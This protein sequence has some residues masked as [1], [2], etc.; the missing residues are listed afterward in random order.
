MPLEASWKQKSVQAADHPL[1]NA[2]AD[3]TQH[4]S[5]HTPDH[6]LRHL[7]HLSRL[8]PTLGSRVRVKNDLGKWMFPQL[9]SKLLYKRLYQLPGMQIRYAKNQFW[10]ITIY[11]EDKYQSLSMLN[12]DQW[13]VIFHSKGHIASISQCKKLPFALIFKLLIFEVWNLTSKSGNTGSTSTG[14]TPGLL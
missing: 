4:L 2:L 9:Q 14:V 7:F 12:F 11:N 13:L 6:G 1:W 3:P 5:S 10:S 8:G